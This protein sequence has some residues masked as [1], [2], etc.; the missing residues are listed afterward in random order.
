MPEPLK[1]EGISEAARHEMRSICRRATVGRE[2]DPKVATEL[3]AHLEDKLLAYLAGE[4]PLT[5][6]DA[7]ILV[8]EHFGRP[9]AL[10]QILAD[11]HSEPAAAG[12]PLWRR[13]A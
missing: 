3:Y 6:A 7:V 10:R 4:E 12:P 1:Y 9:E 13:I 5:E 8:R 11:V 2:I